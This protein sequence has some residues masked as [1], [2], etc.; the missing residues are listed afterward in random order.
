MTVVPEQVLDT[1]AVPGRAGAPK[2]WR[3]VLRRP[4]AAVSAGYLLALVLASVLAPV[5]A[6]YGPAATDLDQ[7]L[8]G[9]TTAHP[10]GTDSL[11]RDVLTRLMYG[12]QVS[13]LNAAVVVLTV[14]LVGVS[15]GVAAG[16][17]DGWLDRVATWVLDMMLAIPVIVT[18][19]AV[20][21]AV[22][23]RQ[24]IGMVA[25]GVLVSPGLARVVRGATLAV[26]EELYIAAA[27]VSGLP[28]RHIVVKHVLPRV[29]GPIIVQISLLAGGALLID[30]G[31]SYLG[32]GAQPP[33]A[34]W[35]N[36][37]AEAAAVIDRQ[38]WLLI[39][40]GV[41]LGLAILA[42]GLLGDTVRDATAARSGRTP[43][44][45]RPPREVRPPWPGPAPRSLLSIQDV[46][47]TLAP[48]TVV[49]ERLDLRIDAGETVGL[50]G[51]SGCGK[52]ITAR[53][54]LGLLPVGARVSAGNIFFDGTEL[55]RL[56]QRET[57]RLR[58][59]RIALVSQEPVSG[60]DPVYTA[61]RQL[62]ELVRRHHGG[63]RRAVRTH[64]LDLLRSVDFPDPRA[65]ADR[66]PHE[67]SGGMAQRVAIAMALAGAPDLL[68]ADEPTTALDVTV[69]AEVLGLLRGLQAEHGM[70]ILLISHDWGVVAAMCHRAYVMYA[71]HFVESGEVAE[72]F[73]RPRHPYTAG[74]LGAVTRRTRPGE[75]LATIPGM[76]PEPAAW[77]RGCHFAP[78]CRL[79][80]PECSAAPVPMLEPS[81]GH[82]TR[83]VHHTKLGGRG[84]A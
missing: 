23:G 58:G 57:R 52:S 28:N 1:A 67:L 63:S 22:D 71:G 72:L 55:T 2:L 59:S 68:I 38:P 80:T 48:D 24:L 73:D 42:F 30:A 51:E 5:L 76:V 60:L 77:P 54:V 6:P 47:I 26:R 29:S 3:T 7:V 84:S 13:L 40:P 9:P 35:G 14:L 74:L 78:R 21:A 61:G 32:F 37:I 39:P 79:A 64:S 16:Y 70:A 36:T 17:L 69:Q 10:L 82:H 27:R 45:V 65:V 19:L 56:G 50:I 66:Y 53:A 25:L 83:C 31:L 33:T 18:L 41:A 20:L 75:R 34:T 15:T 8:A 62:G 46:S 43:A 4:I 44:R 11:G 81:A 49:A 12:G